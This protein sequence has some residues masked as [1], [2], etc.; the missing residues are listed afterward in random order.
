MV[1]F[2]AQELFLHEKKILGSFY[3]S[4]HVHRD[5]GRMLKFWRAGLLDLDG[6]ISRR[7]GFSEINDGLGV[8]RDG[9]TDVIRQ[10]VTIE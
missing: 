6:M 9:S 1:Q 5:T 7:L 3:G 2:N 10:V 8:L 4:A